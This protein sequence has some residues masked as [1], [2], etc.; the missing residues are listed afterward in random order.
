MKGRRFLS[1]CMI[2]LMSAALMLGP[3]CAGQVNAQERIIHGTYLLTQDDGYIVLLTLTADGSAF[4]QQSG[5]FEPPGAFADQQ[6]SWKQNRD[7]TILVRTLDFTRN[8]ETGAFTGFGRCQYNFKLGR[9]GTLKGDFKVEI[10]PVDG[11][12]LDFRPS[13]PP[14]ETSGPIGFTGRRFTVK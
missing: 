3:L 14:T 6:G 1:V 4:S 7:G 10:F 11:D 12:P 13:N 8:A 9:D 2:C 5:Q